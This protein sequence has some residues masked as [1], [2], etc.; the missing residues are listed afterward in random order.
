MWLTF[1][2]FEVFEQDRVT[3][4]MLKTLMGNKMELKVALLMFQMV[5][6]WLKTGQLEVML[7]K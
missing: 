7:M 3:L 5:G 2:F 1:A 6:V 4:M